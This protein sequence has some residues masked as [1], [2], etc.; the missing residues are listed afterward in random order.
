MK[1]L[2]KIYDPGSVEDRLYSKWVDS[3]YFH[4]Q[5]DPE[6]KP[7]TIVMP[8]PNIT[9]VSYTHLQS[10]AME[11]SGYAGKIAYPDF[12]FHIVARP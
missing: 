1:Q 7:Y 6:K 10:F 8:P 9:A 5:R 11:K 12:F 3:G 4:T 2:D